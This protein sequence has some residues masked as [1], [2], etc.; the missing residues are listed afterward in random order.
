MLFLYSPPIFFLLLLR[1]VTIIAFINVNLYIPCGIEIEHK[2]SIEE[3]KSLWTSVLAT[4]S[5][6]YD[7]RKFLKGEKK[8]QS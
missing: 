5:G 6:R 7:C 2:R 1:A 4:V 3:Q 8:K